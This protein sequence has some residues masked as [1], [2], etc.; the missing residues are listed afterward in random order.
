MRK[1][2]AVTWTDKYKDKDQKRSGSATN[3]LPSNRDYLGDFLVWRPPIGLEKNQT[4]W[5]V[6]SLWLG[7]VGA[8]LFLQK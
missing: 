6:L 5:V 8:A 3:Q 1:H 7:L 2:Y 4:F